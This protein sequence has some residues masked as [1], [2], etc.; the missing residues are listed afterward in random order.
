MA[1]GAGTQLNNL[2]NRFSPIKMG[3]PPYPAKYY[4]NWRDEY[5][6]VNGPIDVIKSVYKRSSEGLDFQQNITITFDYEL[7]SYNGINGRQAMLDLISNILNVT[8]NT[9]TFWGGG[10]RGGGAHQNNIFTNL[11][12]F[13]KGDKGK[14]LVGFIESFTESFNTVAKEAQTAIDNNGGV[15]ET[16]KKL[17]NNIG[18]MLISGF[19]NKLGRPQKAMTNS[20]LSPAPVGLWHLTIGN[21]HHPIMSIGNLILKSTTIQHYGP[22]GVDD[23]PTGLKVTCDLIRGKSRDIRDIEKL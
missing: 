10:Y 17:A 19:L 20:L 1:G 5:S 8:Y 16:L 15:I 6:K 14:G 23:F 22:L 12:I 4:N 7:R 13:T 2:F 18:G 11:P 3:N 9:G 21:P